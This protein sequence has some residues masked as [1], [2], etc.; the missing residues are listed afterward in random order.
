MTEMICLYFEQPLPIQFFGISYILSYHSLRA[1]DQIW[2][3]NT[4]GEGQDSGVDIPKHRMHK[5]F[6]P[7]TY[8]TTV[9][10]QI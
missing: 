4:E 9:R 10:R 8:S 7:H 3:G 6:W 5:I 2:H 1:S